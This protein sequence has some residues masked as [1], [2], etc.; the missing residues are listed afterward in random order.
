[1]VENHRVQSVDRA[2]RILEMLARDGELTVGQ[3]ADELQVHSSTAFRLIDTLAAR[4]LLERNAGSGSVRLAAGLLRLAGATASQLDL[5]TEAQPVCDSLAA[6]VGETA[7]VAILSGDVAI[8]VCQAGG[9]SSVS[10]RNWV[11]QHTVLHA[12]ASGKVLLAYLESHQRGRLLRP[13]LQ[14]FTSATHCSAEDL[15]PELAVV[16]RHGWAQSIEEYEEGLNAVAAPIRGHDG[17]VIAALSAA[18]P[19]YRLS[20]ERLPQ[21]ATTVRA[22]AEEVSAKMGHRRETT[23]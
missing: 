3:V 23:A 6:E 14:R 1:M 9:A 12:T 8:N 11:G 7:N 16:R 5:S 20:P 4:E 18:G 15:R 17:A 21:V 13:P 10:M 2:V 22:A 19:T